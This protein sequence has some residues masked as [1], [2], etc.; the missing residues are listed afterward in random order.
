MP[1]LKTLPLILTAVLSYLPF[2]TPEPQPGAPC[3]GNLVGLADAEKHEIVAP[4]YARIDYIGHGLLLACNINW[5]HKYKLGK[6]R[7][8]L[9]RSG[10]QINLKAPKGGQVVEVFWLGPKADADPE[11]VL[12]SLPEQT[13]LVF[14]Q[15][16]RSGLCDLE[17]NVVLAPKYDFIS[18]ASDGEAF[19]TDRLSVPGRASYFVFDCS[20]RSLTALP[21]DGIPQVENL[22]FSEG[23]AA[24]PEARHEEHVPGEPG[25]LWGYIDKTGKFVIGQ[26]FSMAGPF[27]KGMASVGLPLPPDLAQQRF[28]FVQLTL[29]HSHPRERP[30][31]PPLPDYPLGVVIDKTG[32]ILSPKNMNVQPFYGDFAVAREVGSQPSLAGIVDREFKYVVQPQYRG[33]QPIVHF[34]HSLLAGAGAPFSH[35]P[36]FYAT[37]FT[38]TPMQDFHQQLIS[39][40]GHVA[41]TLPGGIEFSVM[42]ISG[43][44]HCCDHTHK[45]SPFVYLNPQGKIVDPPDNTFD[46]HHIRYQEIAPDRLLKIQESDN[47]RFDSLYWKDGD[48]RPFTRNVMFARFLADY[49]LIG[50]T[51]AE[52]IDVLGRGIKNNRADVLDYAVTGGGCTGDYESVQIQFVDD[53]AVSWCFREGTPASEPITTNVL[54]DLSGK[55]S[56]APIKSFNGMRYTV[57]PKH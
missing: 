21:F 56:D 22:Y 7:C 6:E 44:L 10:D 46:A 17:G 51:K 23:L 18:K 20:D 33:L 39:L 41:T 12:Q 4:K 31:P 14:W 5:A 8:V 9:N 54:L 27:K 36:L 35:N 13:L 42:E 11:S 53:K 55:S 30:R 24:F 16:G 48:D 38:H 26:H 19:V 49:D 3:D 47:G 25:P 2:P 32:K 50:M 40:D 29:K 34:H 37:G 57:R 52:V 1:G 28:E 15:E 45:G 43:L